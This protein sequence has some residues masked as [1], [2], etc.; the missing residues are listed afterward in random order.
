VAVI[1]NPCGPAGAPRPRDD[2]LSDSI[3][4]PLPLRDAPPAPPRQMARIRI[5]GLYGLRKGEVM[6]VE[7]ANDCD[8]SIIILKGCWKFF[9]V[10]KE[11]EGVGWEFVD[12]PPTCINP[13]TCSNH[14]GDQSSGEVVP[15]ANQ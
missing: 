7:D 5:D 6:V 4:P 14:Y 13:R 15:Y 1:C 8:G 10:P 2:E 11:D 12:L 9:A 3:L